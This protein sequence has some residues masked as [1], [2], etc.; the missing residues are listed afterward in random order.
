MKLNWPAPF[1]GAH[2]LDEREDRAVL[3][4]LHRRSLFRYY[5][6][7]KPKYAEA[8]ERRAREFYGV[9]YALGVNSGTGALFTA[10]TAM[11][12]GPGGEVIV[13][14]FFWVATVGAIVNA[15]AIP[16]L[17]EVDESFCM[18]PEDLEGKITGRTK[19]IV[20]VHMAGA[21]CDM[22]AI[23]AIAKRRRIPVLEDCAQ[24]NGGSFKGKR[25]GTFG[26]LGMFSLQWNKNA[27]AGEGGVL[28]TNDAALHER[29]V[30][31]HDL[32]I[33]WVNGAPCETG[34]VTWGAGRRMSEL[35][36]A[37]G[38]VQ[39][40]KLPRILS[41]MRASKRRIKAMLEGTS[42]LSF[43][44]LNDEAGDTGA[45]LILR[46]EDE[47]KARAVV[48]RMQ[49]GGLDT[50]VRLAEY[51]LHIYSNIPQLVA[52]TALSP[53]G[54]PWSLPEN[55]ES[56]RDYGKG[57]CPRSDELFSRSL[58]VPIPSRLEASQEKAAAQIIKAALG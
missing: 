56:I 47:A 4:V 48:E 15:N 10:M 24:A 19:L 43:R 53:A 40:K 42:G 58:L 38:S 32:G 5:G 41:H 52:K 29:C 11:G 14:A 37:V 33:P 1:P 13:P 26:E 31:A 46:L 57:A 20:A 18:D 55:Q 3:D 17:C 34:T 6:L 16:V 28:V 30:A 49:A 50:A 51:G 25:V 7:G 36:G 2:W 39:L 35:T 9:R 45:F 27:T 44:R 12:I 54:N 22:K 8:L 21:P 23:M